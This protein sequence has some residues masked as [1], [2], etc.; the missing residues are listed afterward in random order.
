[1]NTSAPAARPIPTD[2]DQLVDEQFV[3][4]Y[5]DVARRT[6]KLWRYE[7]RGPQYVRLASNLIRYRWGDIL[8]FN[9]RQ[10]AVSTSEESARKLNAA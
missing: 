5:Y 2:P 9:A 10:S 7:G 3:A 8:E 1:M 4:N 6:L